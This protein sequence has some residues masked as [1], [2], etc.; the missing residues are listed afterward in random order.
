MKRLLTVLAFSVLSLSSAFGWYASADFQFAR[1]WTAGVHFDASDRAAAAELTDRGTSAV[2]TFRPR[3]FSQIRWQWR[4]SEFVGQ[5][6]NDE[7]LLHLP[8]TIGVH[9]AHAFQDEGRTERRVL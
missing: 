3:E 6:P 1:R 4:R 5:S 7:L 8:F 9:G 2:L